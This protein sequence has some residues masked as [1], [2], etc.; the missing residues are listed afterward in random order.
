V[1]ILLTYLAG[2]SA[3][4]L[5]NILV[6]REQVASS[7]PYEVEIRPTTVIQFSLTSVSTEELQKV[8]ARFF[9][10]LKDTAAAPLDMQY[11]QDC[12]KRERRQVKFYAEG[13]GQYF[14]D[15]IVNDF[16][17]GKRDGSTLRTGLGDLK[18][19]DELETWSDQ[20]W[21]HR[22]RS[23][24]TEAPSVTVLGKPSARLAVKLKADEKARIK[25]RKEKLGAAGLQAL[26]DRLADAKAQNAIPVPGAILHRFAIPGTE[27]IHFINTTSA[28]SGAAR[29]M[30]PLDNDIQR[31]IDKDGDLPLFVHFEHIQSNFAYVTLVLST[32]VIPFSLRPLLPIYMDNF[33]STPMLLSGQ[34]ISFE[35]VIKELERDTIDYG[36]SSGREM[37]NSEII[38]IKLQVEIEKYQAAIRWIRDLM[39]SSV[40]DIERIKATTA[41][42]LADIPDSK[43]DGSDMVNA[44]E[45]MTATAPSSIS[46]ASSTLV[47]AIYLKRVKSLLENDPQAVL[48]RLVEINDS[49]CQP[50][51][52]RILVTADIKKLQRPVQS[53]EQFLGTKDATSP[54]RSLDTRLSR[55]SETGR[56]PGNT[57]YV[58]PMPSIDSSFAL[59]VS[60]G[61]SSLGDPILPAL[62]VA[63]SYLNA[64]EGP[65]WT[66]V[67]G[68]GLAYATN[69]GRHVDSGQISLDI[70]S[71]P[72]AFK[73][74]VACKQVVQDLVSGN[75]PVDRFTLE[76]AVSSIVLGFANAE[77]TRA[78]AAQS[79]FVRQVIRGVPKDWPT[80]ILENVR[81][82]TVEEVKD[83]LRT[84]VLPIF[85]GETANLFVTCAPTM[86]EGLVKGFGELGFKPEVKPLTFFQ[87]D[88]GLQ[89][90]DR[91][92]D[93][94]EEEEDDEDEDM[95][96][97]KID[98]EDTE[99]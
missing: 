40:F 58:V 96:V 45:L 66:A 79:S 77:A 82:V 24:I 71:S 33:F 54:L 57:A 37:G 11:M 95:E 25:A 18:H 49:L 94:H 7:I 91:V 10:V 19:Y 69:M 6:E 92:D 59:L 83:V 15:P 53:W 65:F 61:P 98:D 48:N 38:I 30:G 86:E 34:M 14:N 85:E 50:S 73:A 46:R 74:F 99:E 68:T 62:M 5:E 23:W 64:V 41:R 56:N 44:V 51:N 97:E 17:F 52:I 3:S 16:L 42:L 84:V 26:E 72:D 9:E 39:E 12:I 60:K 13:S 22:L 47:K 55:L 4:V 2:S 29:K 76:G 31:I 89:V 88:Y 32:E 35:Q 43:R 28:R 87:D 93:R 80:I 8:Q 81:K 63:A 75:T 1:L 21:R 36:M 90:Q 27:S 20:E 78:S 67:R 70:Y